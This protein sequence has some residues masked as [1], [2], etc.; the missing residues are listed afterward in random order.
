MEVLISEANR[1]GEI[2]FS[3][4]LI[5]AIMGGK[6]KRRNGFSRYGVWK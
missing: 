1:G 2:L 4:F 3:A 6:G 5:K